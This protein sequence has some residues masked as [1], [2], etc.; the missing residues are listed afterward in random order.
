MGCWRDVTGT[1]SLTRGLNAPLPRQ[2]QRDLCTS[3][4]VSV[5]SSNSFPVP[6]FNITVERDGALFKAR[7]PQIERAK[8]FGNFLEA[9]T[10]RAHLLFSHA[11]HETLASPV[12][13]RSPLIIPPLYYG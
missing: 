6:S 5:D 2:W 8:N 11:K 3:V 12:I 9:S 10:Q 4:E 13:P 1:A 7:R